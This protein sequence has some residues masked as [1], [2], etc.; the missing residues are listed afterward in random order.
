[1]VPF[2]PM[3]LCASDS[4]RI[5]N[6]GGASFSLSFSNEKNIRMARE[7]EVKGEKVGVWSYRL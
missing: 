4:K 1:M 2:I 5:K 6:V 7:G 3:L